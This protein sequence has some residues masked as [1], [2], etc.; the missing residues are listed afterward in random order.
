MIDFPNFMPF[1]LLRCRNLMCQMPG[2]WQ[3]KW[4]TFRYSHLQRMS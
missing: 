4:K 2:L 1:S 3:G